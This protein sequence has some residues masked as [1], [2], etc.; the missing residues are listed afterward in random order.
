LH[1]ALA[2]SAT[3]LSPAVPPPPA[4][5]PSGPQLDTGLLDSILGLSGRANGA[6]VQYSIGRA[7]TITENGHQLLPAM[8]V[9]TALNFQPA[10]ASTA[11]ITGD[12]SLVGSEVESV[13][14]A[15]RSN[16][17]DVTAMHQ[18]HINEQPKI[19]YMHF[20]ANGD[21]GTLAQG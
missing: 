16:G 19:Y 13:A 14:Q 5:P 8:G 20:W 6:V 2:P 12:F 21:P 7:E 1:Q 11:A 3:P 15:L 18:H 9:A 4:A 10:G 17:I